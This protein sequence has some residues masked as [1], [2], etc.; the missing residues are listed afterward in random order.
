MG[1]AEFPNDVQTNSVLSQIREIQKIYENQLHIVYEEHDHYEYL[2]EKYLNI[3][4]LLYNTF[5]AY[6][7]I[8]VFCNMFYLFWFTL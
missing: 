4:N 5:Y 7:V 1:H 2:Y 3:N 6:D 8:A